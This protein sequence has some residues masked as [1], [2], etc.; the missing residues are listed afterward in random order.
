MIHVY[1]DRAI[2]MHSVVVLR[3]S[4]EYIDNINPG[5]GAPS[6]GIEADV[7]VQH[8]GHTLEGGRRINDLTETVFGEGFVLRITSMMKN[9][10]PIPIEDINREN[11][12][13]RDAKV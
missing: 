10:M 7:D 1:R 3:P 12:R 4:W 5:K 13:P 11:L 2:G 8:S 6:Q 9:K